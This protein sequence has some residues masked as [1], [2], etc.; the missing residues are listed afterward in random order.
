ME[1]IFINYCK[2]AFT[3]SLLRNVAYAPP[4]TKDAYMTDRVMKTL[5]FTLLAP[6][7][8]PRCIYTDL[9]NLEHRVRRMPGS[10]DRYPW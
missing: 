5:G 8:F 10:I 3:Y 7:L 4:M 2:G 1:R 6:W 9:K